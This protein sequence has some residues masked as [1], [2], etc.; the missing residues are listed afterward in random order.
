[1]KN[2]KNKSSNK[3]KKY[4]SIIDENDKLFELNQKL[5]EKNN[6]LN[7]DFDDI[8]NENKK[9]KEEIDILKGKL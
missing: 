5:L 1:L 6:K 4:K 9:L 8:M 3:D 7:K 2:D